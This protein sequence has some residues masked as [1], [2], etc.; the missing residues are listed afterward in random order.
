[1]PDKRP[2]VFISHA[3]PDA[4][5][6]AEL[7]EALTSVGIDARLD[8]IDLRL[9]DNVIKWM[10]DA[11][12]ES[13]YL[14]VLVSANSAGRYWLETEWSA[15]LAREAD[16]R[17]TFVV[18]VILPG[19]E[20]KEIPFLLRSKLYLDMRVDR[21]AALLQ[22][23]NFLKQDQQI[24]REHGRLPSPAPMS[25]QEELT[26]DFSECSEWLNVV[27]FS[28]RFARTFRFTLPAEATPSYVLSLLRTRL[29]LKWSNIDSDLMVELSYTYAIGFHGKHLPLDT[30][31]RESGVTDGS[32]LEL[33]IR[34]TL[35]DL[36]EKQGKTQN[37]A[38]WLEGAG[39][40]SLARACYFAACRTVMADRAFSSSLKEAAVKDETDRIMKL[41]LSNREF[42][43]AQIAMIAQRYFSH[44]DA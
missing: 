11:A 33:W 37:T 28:N 34:V 13:D 41:L 12:T 4:D 42:T 10:N 14:L 26:H 3:G 21:E 16:L 39:K 24:A 31:M 44:V 5:Q 7:Q 1:M 29:S 22:L 27:V 43:S 25:A 30:P 40:T 38:Q 8:Q 9:G 23:V 17:R 32:L 15:A 18:P 2:T 20:D 19:V 36:L 35:T 6:A